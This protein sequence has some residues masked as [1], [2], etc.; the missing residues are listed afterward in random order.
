MD[1]KE[2]TSPLA[3]MLSYKFIQIGNIINRSGLLHFNQ[4]WPFNFT[5][6]LCLLGTLKTAYSL[7]H[8]TETVVVGPLLY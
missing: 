6:S 8:K 7:I 2:N 5:L 1:R 3:T 4:G